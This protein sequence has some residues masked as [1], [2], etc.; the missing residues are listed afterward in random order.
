ML[1]FLYAYLHA[2]DF[3]T[4][5]QIRSLR[6]DRELKSSFYKLNF[7]KFKNFSR[8]KAKSAF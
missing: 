8:F 5:F 4:F 6:L 7:E 2:P 3:K 1:N